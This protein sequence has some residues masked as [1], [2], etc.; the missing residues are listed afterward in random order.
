M[1]KDFTVKLDVLLLQSAH[2]RAVVFEPIFLECG[3]D[4]YY[5]EASHKAFLCA[6][7]A[8]RILASVAKRVYRRAFFL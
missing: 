3:V 6:S 1:G 5:M 2:E 7:V 8:E 4:A